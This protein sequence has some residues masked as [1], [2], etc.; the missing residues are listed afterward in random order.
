MRAGGASIRAKV[1]W[2]LFEGAMR[3]YVLT[4]AVLFW[5]NLWVAECTA[6]T[7]SPKQVME[8]FVR[9]EVEGKRL[10]PQGWKQL[11]AF[12][13]HP[14]QIATRPK[15]FV[16]GGS[17]TVWDAVPQSVR[18]RVRVDVEVVPKGHIDS[19]ASFLP[20]GQNFQKSSIIFYLTCNDPDSADGKWRIEG[21]N[22]VVMLNVAAAIDYVKRVAKESKDQMVRKNASNTLEHLSKLL[23]AANASVR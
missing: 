23:P 22:D 9:M 5:T 19:Q 17:L 6:V 16:I 15:I 21:P 2:R 10:T 4:V 1:L 8:Q 14:D 3:P 20:I 11:S 13:V 12:F 7:D 18:G